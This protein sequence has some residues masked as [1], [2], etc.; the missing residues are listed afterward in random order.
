MIL[1]LLWNGLEAQPWIHPIDGLPLSSGVF[2][3]L[4]TNHLHSGLDYRTDSKIG[5]PIRAV[6]IGHIARIKTSASGYGLALY[7]NHPGGYTTVYAHLDRYASPIAEWMKARHYQYQQFELDMALKPKEL[8]VRQGQII[9]YSGNSGGSSGPHLHFEVRHTLSEDI[10]NPQ[11]LGLQMTDQSPPYLQSLQLVQIPGI[12]YSDAVLERTTLFLEQDPPSKVR[13]NKKR[14]GKR[15]KKHKSSVSATPKGATIPKATYLLNKMGYPM[16]TFSH[17]TH[18][19]RYPAYIELMARDRQDSNELTTGVYR[20][21]ILQNRDTV[22]DFRA[23][24]FHFDQTRYGNSVMDYVA[25]IKDRSQKHRCQRS[26]GNLLPMY[27]TTQRNGLL[28]PSG[29]RRLD[30]IQTWCY[31]FNGNSIGYGFTIAPDILAPPAKKPYIQRSH[32]PLLAITRT[33]TGFRAHLPAGTVYD[34]ISLQINTLPASPGAVSLNEWVLHDPRIPVHHAFEVQLQA[35]SGR[36]SPALR[37]KVLLRNR[38]LG[39]Q[40]NYLSGRWEGDRFRAYAKMFGRMDLVIDTVPPVIK[41]LIKPKDLR[42]HH[43]QALYFRISDAMSG[44]ADYRFCAGDEWILPN[45]DAKNNLLIIHLDECM[46]LGK[47]TME[48]RVTD[49]VGNSRLHRFP[50]EIEERPLPAYPQAKP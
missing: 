18:R 38:G 26:P 2:G 41:S 8:P 14:K 27:G 50:L 34:S 39:G 6:A 33:A 4:R 43:G 20:I 42:R 13:K 10:I 45:Y 36:V 28:V 24:R 32:G 7:I 11:H 12:G 5:V 40:V 23:D 37:S 44:I 31:D 17:P 47:Q 30:S 48:L 29:Q 46:P 3:E 49:K 1:A 9:G 15:A 35:K 25:R 16:D 22:Y 21:V 19:L